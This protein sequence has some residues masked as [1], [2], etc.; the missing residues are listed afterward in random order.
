MTSD[1][2]PPADFALTGRLRRA[3]EQSGDK[4]LLNDYNAD[5]EK[6][7][8]AKIDE[9]QAEVEQLKK[10]AAGYLTASWVEGRL[11]TSMAPLQVEMGWEKWLAR[12][13]A[14]GVGSMLTAGLLLWL[15][16]HK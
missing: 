15:E 11:Q 6:K 10:D 5:I 4:T 8:W 2:V 12:G 3:L 7:Q 1:V 9:L 16:H 14:A 13:A